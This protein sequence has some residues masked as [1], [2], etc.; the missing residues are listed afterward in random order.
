[1]TTDTATADQRLVANLR[2][3]VE[4]RIAP[5][6]Y[7]AFVGEK[8]LVDT[9]A[10][11]PMGMLRRVDFQPDPDH[12]GETVKLDG[13]RAVIYWARPVPGDDPRVVGAIVHEDGTTQ[14]FFAVIPPP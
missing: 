7:A 10:G 4:A 14:V 5:D 2:A 12:P 3:A 6:Q 8:P 9:T 11:T 1:M 13:A